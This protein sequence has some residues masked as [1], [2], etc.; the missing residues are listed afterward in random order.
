M[1]SPGIADIVTWLPALD[2]GMTRSEANSSKSKTR[3]HKQ[4][5]QDIMF[6]KA[7]RFAAVALGAGLLV[8]GAAPAT[9]GSHDKDD[10][11][12][13]QAFGP[14]VRCGDAAWPGQAGWMDI[15]QDAIRGQFL[16]V[17]WERVEEAKK[18]DAYEGP[19]DETWDER[20]A[21]GKSVQHHSVRTEE[22]ASGE[23]CVH[24][25]VVHVRD[26]AERGLQYTVECTG[27]TGES[28]SAV[29]TAVS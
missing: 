4:G 14:G 10:P 3:G 25:R 29:A 21:D 19:W 26:G 5:V 8:A 11:F 16:Q 23:K 9:A 6:G 17:A 13:C 22:K 15:F 7:Q 28:A 24:R 18:I 27:V 2:R 12:V 20:S 1:M